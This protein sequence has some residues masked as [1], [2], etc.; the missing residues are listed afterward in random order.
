MTFVDFFFNIKLEML[1]GGVKIHIK[2]ITRDIWCWMK[3]FTKL[4]IREKH[5][6]KQTC[7]SCWLNYCLKLGG[8]QDENHQKTF[9]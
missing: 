2:G 6:E 3:F 7:L 9:T 4:G 1:V 5:S 8:K